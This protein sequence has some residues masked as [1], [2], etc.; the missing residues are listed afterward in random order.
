MRRLGRPRGLAQAIA[1]IYQGATRQR[2]IVHLE[3]DVAGWFSR[4]EVVGGVPLGGVHDATGRLGSHRR[5]RK[6]AGDELPGHGAVARRRRKHAGHRADTEGD[7][8]EG[9]DIRNGGDRREVE[10]S[11]VMLV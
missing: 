7:P 1:E 8:G 5:E 9:E 3:R 11:D 4:K 2:C 6:M 10:E